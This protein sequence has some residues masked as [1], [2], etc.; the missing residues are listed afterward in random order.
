MK[1]LH[2]LTEFPKLS[3]ANSFVV[4]G[5]IIYVKKDI[6]NTIYNAW[7]YPSGMLIT[8]GI[9]KDKVK[10]LIESRIHLLHALNL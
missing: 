2:H 10:Q 4:D 9:T 7:L 8:V 6:S 5:H 1:K 3:K